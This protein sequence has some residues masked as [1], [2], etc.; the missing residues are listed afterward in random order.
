MKKE[1]FL[2][3][4]VFLFCS[5]Y[6]TM[7]WKNY[8]IVRG[9]HNAVLSES[10][11]I[12]FHSSFES[13][14]ETRNIFKSVYGNFYNYNFFIKI[15]YKNIYENIEKIKFNELLLLYNETEV[16]LLN[17]TDLNISYPYPEDDNEEIVN[18]FI[19]KDELPLIIPSEEIEFSD[20][21]LG[22][23]I[24]LFFNNIEINFDEVD[25]LTMKYN[26]QVFKID[27]TISEFQFVLF[28]ERNINK[29]RIARF[30]T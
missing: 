4:I 8:D 20:Y 12:N 14:L 11:E 23:D 17:F 6:E 22:M 7:L 29:Y 15:K 9:S 18:I 16:N 21:G 1:Y 28:Y 10:E 19:N 30:T 13:N 25:K 5:C 24:G 27:G 3:I 2:I 26:I